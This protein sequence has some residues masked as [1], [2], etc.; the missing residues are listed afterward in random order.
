MIGVERPDDVTVSKTSEDGFNA[1]MKFHLYG[2]SA[3]GK[4]VSEYATTDESGV[5][6]FKNVLIAGGSGYTLEEVETAIRYVIPDDL[7]IK[8]NWKEVTN[9]S[10]QNILKKF[11]V[12]VNKVDAEK[13]SSQGDATL[14]GA[15]FEVFADADKDAVFDLKKD[16]CL[17]TLTELNGGIYEMEGL[18][19]GDYF[20]KEKSA[21]EGRY[22]YL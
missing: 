11:N 22:H 20:V 5:A 14:A 19:Y 21:N 3:S 8:V 7:N 1:G 2:T 15:V 9:T 18:L 12:T 17:G 6:T 10:V 4:E 16:E 13:G